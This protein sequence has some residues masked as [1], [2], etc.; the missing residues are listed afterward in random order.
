MD[1]LNGNRRFPISNGLRRNNLVPTLSIIVIV[2]AAA[3]SLFAP[4]PETPSL[5]KAVGSRV[6][7]EGVVVRDPDSR[8][9]TVR[10]TLRPEQV[11]GAV[12]YDATLVLI[13]GDRFTDASYGDRIRATGILKKPE[14]F[15][16]DS[17]R[18][19][20]YPKYLLAHGVTH[21][22]S[23][24]NVEIVSPGTGNPVVALLL[25][26]KHAL[27]RGIRSALPEPESALLSG[28]LLGDKQSLGDEINDAF[29]RAGVVHII[30][31]SGYNVSLVIIAVTFISLRVLPRAAAYGVTAL[32]V[33]AFAIMTGGSE[34]TI[35]A[36]VMALLMILAK[37]LHRPGAALRGLLIAAAAMALWNPLLVLYDLSF[38]LSVVATLGLILFSDSIA[39]RMPFVPKSLG[40]RDIVSTTLATQITVLPLLIFSVGAVSLVFLPANVLVLPAVPVAMLFGFISA[41]IALVS[42]ALAFPV[43]LIAYGV[44]AYIV[45]ISVWFGSLPFSSVAI[46]QNIAWI[47]LGVI[48]AIYGFIAA[49]CIPF[50][51]LR[52]TGIGETHRAG[53]PKS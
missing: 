37:V 12:I 10:L 38:Q 17:G 31:L 26:I 13:S 21:E 19:F 29:R 43:S 8:E 1:T 36:T 39:A 32:F 50:R 20:D 25:D 2:G 23:F 22:L 3:W 11:N 30:V 15:A 33:I 44:L 52:K 46:P 27:I 6:Q 9:K 49:R 5:D 7:I 28:L 51:A 40:V 16:T 4:L 47:V 42:S 53:L 45:N 18:T 24:A 35:R 14:A 34:T 41:L 48:F